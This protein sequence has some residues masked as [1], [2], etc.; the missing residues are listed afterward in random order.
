MQLLLLHLD[1]ALELQADFVRSCLR[2]GG[3]EIQASQ[4]GPTIRLWSKQ[5]NLDEFGERLAKQ[6]WGGRQEPRLCFIGSGDFHHVTSLLLDVALRNE[7]KS[8]T[9]VHFDNHPDWVRFSGGVHCGS[10]VNRAVQHAKVD[11]VITVGVCSSDLKR[12]EWKRANL[13]LLVSGALELY[14]YDHAPSRVKK[15]Y[16]SGPSHTQTDGSLRWNT[17]AS[18]GEQHFI[19]YLLSRIKTDN[20]YLTI[21][22]D[23]FARD[24]AVTNWDQG[25]MRLRYLLSV[26][27]AIGQLHRI[28]GAD[29]IGDYSLPVYGGSRWTVLSKHAEILIDQPHRWPDLEHATRVNSAANHQLLEALSEI[30]P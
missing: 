23:V 22:K 16:R 14:P 21:D 12:P 20:V 18:S 8:A 9:V 13:S 28:I 25:R 17:I 26:I 27:A 11:K 2:A 6:M 15:D 10:W 4:D 5:K 1:D 7:E 24:D 3:R 19:D 29:V 30:M